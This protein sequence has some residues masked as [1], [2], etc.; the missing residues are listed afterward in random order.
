MLNEDEDEEL[1]PF[2][3]SEILAEVAEREPQHPQERLSVFEEHG[4]TWAQ[5]SQC[6]R[7]WSVHEAESLK[8]DVYPDLETV[9]EGDGYC[10]DNPADEE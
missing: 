4:G 6:G 8:R 2:D 5:C 7:Q 9:S 3:D 10:D 1:P